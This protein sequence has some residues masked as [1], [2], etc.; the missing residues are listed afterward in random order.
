MSRRDDWVEE[1]I[2]FEDAES[3]AL[4]PFLLTGGRT[5][6]AV[7]GLQFETLVEPS[8]TN[9]VDD[10]RFEAAEVMRLC[11]HAISVAEIS[12]H[13]SIPLQST[14][15]LIGDLISSG[16]LRAHQ[17][18]DVASESGVSLVERLIAGVKQL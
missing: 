8:T 10:L 14:M 9:S 12:A 11:D 6:A 1:D 17:T 15:V 3:T 18:V 5:R 13:L 4:R 16:H 7:S 2:V